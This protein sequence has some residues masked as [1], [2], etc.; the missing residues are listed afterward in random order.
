MILGTRC[1]RRCRF[2]AADKGDPQPAD[3]E[4]LKRVAQAAQTLSLEYV[5]VTSVTRDDLADG[6]SVQLARTI[7]CI[8]KNLPDCNVEVLVP[9]FRGSVSALRR[10]CEAYP[11]VFNHTI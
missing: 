5:V 8:Y 1:T 2:C 3:P 7:E 10:V 4:E 6:G 11:D 9:D